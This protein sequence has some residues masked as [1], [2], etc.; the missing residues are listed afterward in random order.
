ME[1]LFEFSLV[2]QRD[3]GHDVIPQFPRPPL[4]V[5]RNKQLRATV[6]I[7]FITTLRTHLHMG[8]ALITALKPTQTPPTKIRITIAFDSKTTIKIQHGRLAARAVQS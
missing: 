4:S 5:M 8:M 1:H 2:F 6:V 7:A 3:F